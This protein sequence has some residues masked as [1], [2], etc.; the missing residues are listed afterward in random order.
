MSAN[1]K[2]VTLPPGAIRV[3]DLVL[4]YPVYRHLVLD[5][6]R[7]LL[8]AL[9]PWVK[10]PFRRVLD[11]ITLS[12]NPGEVVG[13]VGLNGVGKTSLL[14]TIAGLISPTAGTVRVGGRVMALLAMG[15]G[16]RPAFT[17]RQNLL[18]GGLLLGLD[19]RGIAERM[20]GIAEFSELG[21]ALDQPYFTYSSGMRARLA[22]SLATSVPA[23]VVI[24]D[25][26]LATGDARFISKCYRRLKEIRASGKTILFVSHNLGEVARI[27]S[28]VILLD[29][30]RVA[31]D[32]GV[33]EGLKVYVDS[34]ADASPSVSLDAG[35]SSDLEV[36]VRVQDEQGRTLKVVELGQRIAIEMRIGSRRELGESSV[37]LRVT[38][39]DSNELY[40]YLS[41]RRWDML[42]EIPT[43]WDSV[44]VGTG[45]TTITWTIPYWTGG[46]GGYFIDAYVG[47]ACP[48][49]APDVAD[50]RFW[51]KVACIE[52]SY[53]NAYLRGAGS[54]AELPVESVTVREAPPA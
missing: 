24:L 33:F 26:T 35:R 10:P 3:E 46:E 49:E 25:E 52:G 23:D 30:G 14:K 27:T 53:G 20:Q 18:I 29:H 7:A 36:S 4:E 50:G 13:I 22:F 40:A 43:Q 1:G 16:F 31:F 51:H 9:L 34:F 48:P 39:M 19:A 2:P 54:L 41:A 17:G 5:R 38:R 15:V 28:R 11:R 12:I 32:G 47:P 6:F 37:Y 45:V 21:E 44:R 8:G 42:R